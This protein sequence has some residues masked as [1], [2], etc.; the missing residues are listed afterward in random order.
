MTLTSAMEAKC[1]N[2]QPNPL[3][4]DSEGHDQTGAADTEPQPYRGS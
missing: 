3:K 4:Q 1:S 2:E